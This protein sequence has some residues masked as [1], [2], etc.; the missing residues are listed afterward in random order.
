MKLKTLI[1]VQPTNEFFV[2]I[3]CMLLCWT[4]NWVADSFRG[5]LWFYLFYEGLFAL[6]VCI[7]L[8]A[9]YTKRV[10]KRSLSSIGL[11]LS[12]WPRALAVGVG[13]SALAF[14][15]RYMGVE[16]I[17][18]FTP[19]H[20]VSI[21]CCMLFSTL[22]EEL[23]FRGFLQSNFERQFGII[24]A[25]LLSSACFAMYHSAQGFVGFDL[26]KLLTLFAIGI[27]FSISFRITG[28][29]LTSFLVNAPQAVLTFVSETAYI[30]YGKHFTLLSAVIC[31]VSIAA[32]CAILLAIHN[33][34]SGVTRKT[35][36]A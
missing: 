13:I 34:D 33:G 2:L 7:A 31:L 28:S 8:P 32:A 10:R 15:G 12:R 26:P 14:A 9:W 36:T 22:F 1:R 11:D 29:I 27:V 19:G 18:F 6:G 30:E 17:V 21:I 35:V 23:F 5:T 4:A 3:G 20:L 25:I 24:P 16:Q